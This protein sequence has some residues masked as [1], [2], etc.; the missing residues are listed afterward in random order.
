MSDSR[1][2]DISHLSAADLATLIREQSAVQGRERIALV[3]ALIE[4]SVKVKD[5]DAALIDKVA[6]LANI[7]DN[8]G[9]CGVLSGGCC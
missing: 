9:G 6:R 4:R 8:N 5:I 1:S 7:G 3:D 2:P